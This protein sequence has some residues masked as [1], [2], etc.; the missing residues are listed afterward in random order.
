VDQHS[1]VESIVMPGDQKVEFPPRATT[2]IDT[3]IGRRLRSRREMLGLTQTELG[4]RCG[5]SAQQCHKYEAG[6]SGMRASRLVQCG[7]VLGVPVSYF[8]N[9]LEYVED[10]PDD[11]LDLLTD[12]KNSELI[13]LFSQITEPTIQHGLLEIIRAAHQ[14]QT[15]SEDQAERHAKKA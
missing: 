13:R 11:L 2:E 12:R 9:S 15:A 10:F 14:A 3:K 8:F 5:V 7:L 6:L 1:L 4:Q